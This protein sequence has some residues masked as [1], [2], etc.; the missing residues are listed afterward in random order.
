MENLIECKKSASAFLKRHQQNVL[1]NNIFYICIYKEDLALNI[2]Q[3]LLC[4]KTKAN[5]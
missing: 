3:W 2:L 4:H 1:T 5:Q